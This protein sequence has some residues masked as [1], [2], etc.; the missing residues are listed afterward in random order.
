MKIETKYFFKKIVA[1][2]II[3]GLA[4]FLMFFFVKGVK[5]Q[6]NKSQKYYDNRKYDG[7]YPSS[8]IRE[9]WQVCSMTFQAKQPHLPQPTRWEVCDC[10]V[11]VIRETHTPEEAHT[12]SPEN[13][14]KLSL[15]LINQCN[16]KFGKP[17]EM[18]ERPAID[19]IH[20][21]HAILHHYI[22]DD[23]DVL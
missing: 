3:L 22:G 5:A 9:L 12:L 1:G 21:N 15:K 6:D 19:K 23:N 14:K 2:L 13:A 8:Q 17:S 16:W 10:Y 18:T 11:D 20:F 7:N 4:L